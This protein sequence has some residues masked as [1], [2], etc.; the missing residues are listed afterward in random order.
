MTGPSNILFVSDSFRQRFLKFHRPIIYTYNTLRVPTPKLFILLG[1][2]SQRMIDKIPE[3]F[4]YKLLR[5]LHEATVPNMNRKESIYYLIFGFL[6]ASATIPTIYLLIFQH[7]IWLFG[8]IVMF[9]ACL[10]VLLIKVKV[11]IRIFKKVYR[12]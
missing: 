7:K 8:I 11:A 12:V 1:L 5:S 4:I 3:K 2:N 10:F 6:T 9:V